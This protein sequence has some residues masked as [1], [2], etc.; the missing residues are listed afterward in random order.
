MN[1]S[2]ISQI[3]GPACSPS[4]PRSDAS[5][6]SLLRRTESKPISY[7]SA[8]L[9]DIRM[10]RGD[11]IRATSGRDETKPP[12]K[13]AGFTNIIWK[14][15]SCDFLLNNVGSTGADWRPWWVLSSLA[16]SYQNMSSNK[17]FAPY[18]TST[19]LPYQ[20]CLL[21]TEEKTPSIS[22]MTPALSCMTARRTCF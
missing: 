12:L 4:P 8:I 18:F 16:G 7:Q 9:A 11:R 19:W 13:W 1:S 15:W 5:Q 2:L 10:K 3:I 20:T 6:S 21:N 14:G 22:N 17:S